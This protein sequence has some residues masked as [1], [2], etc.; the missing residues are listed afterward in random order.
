MEQKMSFKSWI[1][2]L[3]N[4]S[5][6]ELRLDILDILGDVEL[7]KYFDYIVNEI[8]DRGIDLEKHY[9]E[10]KYGKSGRSYKN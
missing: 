4:S 7:L 5:Q 6:E 10:G 1:K 3:N 2:K 8:H 9:K